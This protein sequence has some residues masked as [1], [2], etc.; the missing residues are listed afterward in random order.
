MIIVAND[1]HVKSMIA[2]AIKAAVRIILLT[3]HMASPFLK[4]KRL[5]PRFAFEYN[6]IEPP[7]SRLLGSGLLFAATN[8]KRSLFNLHFSPT[9]FHGIIACHPSV[10]TLFSSARPRSWAPALDVLVRGPALLR[11]S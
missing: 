2:A 7:A 5:T 3:D 8:E 9:V 11:Y 6:G 10:V 4:K 1:E